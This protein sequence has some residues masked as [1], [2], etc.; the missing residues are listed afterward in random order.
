[1][2]RRALWQQRLIV[3]GASVLGVL[4]LDLT[5][6]DDWL[7]ETPVVREGIFLLG[8]L[9]FGALAYFW[10]FFGGD[11]GPRKPRDWLYGAIFL[12]LAIGQAVLLT[13]TLIHPE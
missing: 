10:L 13:V 5:G 9:F 4:A 7:F 2:T 12:L 6:A 1:M 3:V 8:I 11:A